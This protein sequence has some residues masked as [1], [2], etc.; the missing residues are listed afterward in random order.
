MQAAA[1]CG[2]NSLLLNRYRDGQDKLDWHADDEP[3]PDPQAPTASL[4]FGAARSFRL[5]PK[6]P[7][8]AESLAY[9][10]GHGDLLVMDPPTQQHWLHQ[11]P[12][13][14]RIR[15]ERINLTFR[16]IRPET[17]RHV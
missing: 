13:R 3:E 1:G 12:Q 17:I 14:L 6:L 11:V 7:G 16:T 4:S 10:L 8:T 9:V 15:E 2:F 5:R